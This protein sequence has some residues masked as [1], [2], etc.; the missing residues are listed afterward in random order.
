MAAQ[1]KHLSKEGFKTTFLL[2]APLSLAF[3]GEQLFGFVDVLVAGHLGVSSLAA[4]GLSNAIF[5]SAV[6]VGMG[7]ISGIEPIVAQARGRE[8][9]AL[10]QR[11]IRSRSQLTLALTPIVVLLSE[12][13]LYLYF[14]TARILDFK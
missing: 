14:H 12:V 10:I 4:I 8:N 13:I 2:A 3:A 9:H 1:L 11:F 6:I 7:L 5:M